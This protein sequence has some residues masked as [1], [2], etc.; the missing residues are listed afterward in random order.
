MLLGSYYQ[1]NKYVEKE[2]AKEEYKTYKKD[3][4]S[5]WHRNPNNPVSQNSRLRQLYSHSQ[6]Y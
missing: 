2:N 4:R 3:V 6:I 1:E 5:E